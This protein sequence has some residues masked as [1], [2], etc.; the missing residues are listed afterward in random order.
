VALGDQQLEDVPGAVVDPAALEELVAVHHARAPEREE[1]QLRLRGPRR[2]A[3]PL[4][5]EVRAVAAQLGRD[6]ATVGRQR[7]QR[8]GRDVEPRAGGQLDAQRRQRPGAATRQLVDADA[9]EPRAGRP[10]ADDAAAD[11]RAGAQ[12]NRSA[13]QLDGSAVDRH[14]ATVG[15]LDDHGGRRP[16]DELE[17]ELRVDEGAVSGASWCLS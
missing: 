1:A 15:V 12:L 9:L 5:P 16:V 13:E 6:Q 11:E 7:H 10:A 3:T 17:R 14:H 4:L 2:R 8:R